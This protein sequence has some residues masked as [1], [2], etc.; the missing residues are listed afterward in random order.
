MHEPFVN[1]AEDCVP[2]EQEGFEEEVTVP[3]ARMEYGS[4]GQCYVLL[5]REA[6][7]MTLGKLGACMQFTVKE[8]DPSTGDALLRAAA[9]L[10]WT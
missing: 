1:R 9:A 10:A 7:S 6:G 4:L 8:I 3:L 2:C 5:K